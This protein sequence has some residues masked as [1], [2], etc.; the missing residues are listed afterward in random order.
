MRKCSPPSPGHWFQMPRSSVQ[1]SPMAPAA[2]S[3][4]RNFLP[5][6]NRL[7]LPE[8]QNQL[9]IKYIPSSYVSFLQPFRK[10][11]ASFEYRKTATFCQGFPRC[12]PFARKRNSG[13]PVASRTLEAVHGKCTCLWSQSSA[14]K[15]GNAIK[16][17]QISDSFHTASSLV[18]P[19]ST[20][21]TEY[22]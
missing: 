17:F 9:L 19:P 13:F 3:P 2:A 4:R 20:M 11:T 18:R 21:H 14:N 1:W 22:K 5:Q 15:F 16:P 6:K 7:L 10:I 12:F 8:A